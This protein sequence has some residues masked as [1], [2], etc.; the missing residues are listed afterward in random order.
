MRSCVA[1]GECRAR[2]DLGLAALAEVGW[3]YPATEAD[4]GAVLL[5]EVV[6][7]DAWFA[8]KP[9]A[10]DKAYGGRLAGTP[11]DD[12]LQAQMLILRRFGNRRC[13]AGIST[14]RTVAG[15]PPPRCSDASLPAAYLQLHGPLVAPLPNV[16]P[17]RLLGGTSPARP[18]ARLPA[19]LSEC[20]YYRERSISIL[21]L[22]NKSPFL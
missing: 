8:Q 9:D 14:V 22:P 3:Q 19:M 4:C 15:D 6:G 18:F 13:F 5:T 7:L 17:R 1:T 20:L 21:A 2:V 16:S 11:G 10:F 12:A